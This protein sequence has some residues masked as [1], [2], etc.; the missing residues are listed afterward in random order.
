MNYDEN[1]FLV[2]V[3][4]DD[5]SSRNKDNLESVNVRLETKFTINKKGKG[6]GLPEYIEEGYIDLSSGEFKSLKKCQEPLQH[7]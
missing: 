3:I 2:S 4:K 1:G 7:R 6:R 5:G